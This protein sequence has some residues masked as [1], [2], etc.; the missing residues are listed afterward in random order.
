MKYFTPAV[1]FIVALSVGYFGLRLAATK[2]GTSPIEQKV[3]ELHITLTKDADETK[4]TKRIQPVA[5]KAICSGSF[6]DGDGLIL[7]AR[8]CT[9][10]VSS[11]EVL[12]S[13]HSVYEASF[14]TKSNTQDLAL[15]RINR[16]NTPFFTLADAVTRGEHIFILGSPMGET[17]TLSQGFVAKL[18]GDR[19]I[20]DA[21][22]VPGNSGGPVYDDRG[23]LVGV[24][25]AVF[26]SA[27]G[28]T[29]LGVVEGTDAV[30]A[31]LK[32]F[33]GRKYATGTN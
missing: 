3:V 10:G 12:T 7:T 1:T 30:R 26:V 17:D 19:L 2:F 20:V 11:I 31:L 33:V 21:S 8:H 22:V 16:H 6:V 23:N 29:H 27:Y 24:A 14:V 15:I 13:D 18:M 32:D 28:M 5:S 9:E 25:V 4:V